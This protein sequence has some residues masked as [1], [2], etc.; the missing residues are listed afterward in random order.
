M[1]FRCSSFHCASCFFFDVL[2]RIFIRAV[3][4]FF[5]IKITEE[6]GTTKNEASQRWIPVHQQLLLLGF[7]DYVK[8]QRTAQ[9]VPEPQDE[10]IEHGPGEK[11]S[12]PR[13]SGKLFP[14]LHTK[15]ERKST[16]FLRKLNDYFHQELNFERGYT[17][18][19]FRHYW[20]DVLRRVT[21]E[22]SAGGL[23]WP[24]GMSERISGRSHADIMKAE[25]SGAGYGGAI[26]PNLMQPFLNRLDFP[27]VTFPKPWAEFKTN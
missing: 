25:G 20:E 14:E 13:Q 3:L 27:G 11:K 1:Y 22:T 19:S 21:T 23:V 16:Y 6:S 18:H 26:P 5:S 2:N 8:T 17:F 4:T 15:F 12:R 24:K 9:K 10:F 7:E